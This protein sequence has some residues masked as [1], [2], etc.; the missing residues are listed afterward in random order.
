MGCEAAGPSG[1]RCKG[2]VGALTTEW[3]A[4][5]ANALDAKALNANAPR[6][7]SETVQRYTDTVKRYHGSRLAASRE[8][9]PRALV[10]LS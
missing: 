1:Q 6:R 3:N 8:L 10:R 2:R 7:I 5:D 4:L 9:S